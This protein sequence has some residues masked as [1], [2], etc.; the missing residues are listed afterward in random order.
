MYNQLRPKCVCSGWQDPHNQGSYMLVS[1]QQQGS[2]YA[3]TLNRTTGGEG[4]YTD[5]IDIQLVE[6]A[7]GCVLQGC[8]ESQVI[9]LCICFVHQ[10]CACLYRL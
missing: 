2:D 3:L 6:T 9:G 8:S 7:S 5:S 4:K 10:C 1:Q